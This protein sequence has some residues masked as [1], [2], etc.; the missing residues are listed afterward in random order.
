MKDIKYIEFL[1]SRKGGYVV[2]ASVVIPVFI[3]SVLMLIS[4]IPAFRTVAN[5]TFSVCDEMRLES[6]KS[7]FRE[8]SAAAPLIIKGRLK[9]ENTGSRANVSFYRYLYTGNN[10]DD[11]ITLGIKADI[12]GADPLG[13]FGDIS[14][15]GKVTARA[16]TGALIKNAPYRAEDDV[17]VFIFPEN[18]EKYHSERC[19]YVVASCQMC[20][21][22]QEIKKKYK[23]CK[24]CNADSAQIGTVVYL[25]QKSGKAYHV[26][27][28]K[29]VDRYFIKINKSDAVGMGYGPCSKCGGE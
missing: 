11:L 27:N 9:R 8:N 22:S 2:E 15:T 19:T 5:Y 21:L 29:S 6:V 7:A 17:K 1:H 14:F 10:I 16:F 13:I 23:P 4:I 12:S 3:L 24:N 25:F 26:K 20:Y 18:G 28:C